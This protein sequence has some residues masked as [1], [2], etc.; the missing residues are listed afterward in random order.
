MI[1]NFHT[2]QKKPQKESYGFGWGLE[3]RMM[4][5]RGPDE[6]QWCRLK[7][8]LWNVLKVFNGAVCYL[9]FSTSQWCPLLLTPDYF[10]CIDLDAVWDIPGYDRT[11]WCFLKHMMLLLPVTH[12]IISHE[13]AKHCVLFA[14][15]N[16]QFKSFHSPNVHSFISTL[17]LS[18]CLICIILDL[19]HFIS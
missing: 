4:G 16:F 6:V 5:C 9:V 15:V 1:F 14:L 10:H 7:S 11:L 2:H 18:L 19:L 13:I 8:K 17:L 12:I 3:W